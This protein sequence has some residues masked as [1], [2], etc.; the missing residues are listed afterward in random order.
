MMKE[1]EICAIIDS[2]GFFVKNTFFPREISIVND[3]YNIC[4]EVIPDIETDFKLKNFKVFSYQQHQLHGIPIESVLS[5][6]SKKIIHIK[7][8][9]Q[10]IEGIYFRVRTEEKKLFG[11]KNLQLAQLLKEYQIPY[12]NLEQQ[13]VGGELCPTLKEFEKFKISC[14]CSLHAKLRRKFKE[15]IHR[16]AF[17]KAQAIWDWLT[18]KLRSDNL[19]EEIFSDCECASDINKDK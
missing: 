7:N 10:L 6:K 3:E 2:Q 5:E 17:R 13:E 14:H 8:L 16:C 11:V 12:F 4:F 9:R 19:L 18:L 15:E 1:N